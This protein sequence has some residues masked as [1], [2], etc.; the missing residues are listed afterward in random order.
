[1]NDD[2]RTTKRA[3]G[4]IWLAVAILFTP[5]ISRAQSVE[6]GN[7]LFGE[8][9]FS[10][11][12]AVF[13]TLVGV[14][15][16]DGAA[17]YGLARALHEGGDAGADD[18]YERTLELG[19]NPGRARYHFAR[20]K[21]AQ[22]ETGRALELLDQAQRGGMTAYQ[23]VLQTAEFEPLLE[24]AEF[25]AIANRMKPCTATEYA[26]FDFWIGD[27]DVVT[28]AGQPAG[29]NRISRIQGGCALRE[30]WTS[31]TGGT[32]TS[33]NTFNTGKGAWQQFWVDASGTVLEI[34]GG[35]EGRAMVMRSDPDVS[36]LQRIT[37]TPNPDGTVRQHWESSSD[38]GAT[39]STAFDGIYR[40]KQ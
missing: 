30:E 21:A 1:M 3:P 28:P 36:P 2:M 18:A 16:E 33:T 37:W 40:K 20:L 12:A 6:R 31:A 23:V 11:A 24:H 29:N 27:W 7:E 39:W 35:L 34:E 15:A 9:K 13:R 26:D 17:W 10:E 14:N 5:A 19:A 4:A 25:Q 8:G 38:G 22:G 32:G